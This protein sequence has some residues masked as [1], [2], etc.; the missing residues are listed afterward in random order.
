[1]IEFLIIILVT[2]LIL[3]CMLSLIAKLNDNYDS[4]PIILKL[5][6]ILFNF[7]LIIVSA[8]SLFASIYMAII[9]IGG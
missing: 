6:V 3:F 9:V 5:F 2:N 1:M 7:C 4:L 8:S